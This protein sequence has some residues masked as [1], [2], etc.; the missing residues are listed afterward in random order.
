MSPAAA[1]EELAAPGAG[2]VVEELLELDVVVESAS[3][4]VVEPD[5]VTVVEVVEVD[6]DD[7]AV[8]VVEDEAA[9]VVVAL[10]VV[11]VALIVVV[12]PSVIVKLTGL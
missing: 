1:V 2:T 6:P 10:V 11:V 7:P 9:V 4:E 5:D 12:D 3:V 8:V